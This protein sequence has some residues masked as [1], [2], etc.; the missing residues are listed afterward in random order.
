MSLDIVG[1]YTEVILKKSSSHVFTHMFEEVNTTLDKATT[2]AALNLV[3]DNVVV[4]MN[5]ETAK[6]ISTGAMSLTRQGT[7]HGQAEPPVLGWSPPI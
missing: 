4:P 1:A 5:A 2:R 3:G 6:S 7:S